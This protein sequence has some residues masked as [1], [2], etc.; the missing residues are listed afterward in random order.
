MFEVSQI[1]MFEVSQIQMFEVSQIQMFEVSQIQTFDAYNYTFY[2]VMWKTK[3]EDDKLFLTYVSADG[4]EG[5]PGELTLTVMY[6]LSEDNALTIDYTATSTKATPVNFTNH[7]YFNLA[8][9]VTAITILAY[10][11]LEINIEN[12]LTLNTIFQPF[13]EIQL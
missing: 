7:A 13:I 8:G 11:T 2:K 12:K 5:Y 9:Q 4:E 10:F 6:Q 1:Q 3:T